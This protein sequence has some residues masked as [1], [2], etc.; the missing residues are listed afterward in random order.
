MALYHIFLCFLSK[1]KKPDG[2]KQKENIVPLNIFYVTPTIR[3]KQMLKKRDH[4]I[5]SNDMTTE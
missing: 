4:L 3:D 2:K 1:K 5:I